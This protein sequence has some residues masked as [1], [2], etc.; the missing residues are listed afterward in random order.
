MHTRTG[1]FRIGFR[2]IGRAAWQQDLPG[3]GRWA[4][5]TG[6]EFFHLFQVPPADVRKVKETGMDVVSVDLLDWPALLS[7]DS[8]KRKDTIAKNIARFR[9]MAALGVK[10]FF[11][12]IIP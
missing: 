2:F 9:E 7:D 3:L 10:V 8:G 11:A 5:Q 1:N 6:F 12:V 4:K